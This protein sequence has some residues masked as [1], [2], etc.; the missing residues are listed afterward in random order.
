MLCNASIVKL[1]HSEDTRGND[2]DFRCP[3]PRTTLYKYSMY[4]VDSICWNNLP[5]NLKSIN[6]IYQ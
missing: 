5:N 6:I 4:C 2:I 3:Q 1:C